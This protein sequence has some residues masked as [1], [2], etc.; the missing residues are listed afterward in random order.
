MS[1]SVSVLRVDDELESVGQEAAV[2]SIRSPVVRHWPEPPTSNCYRDRLQRLIVEK[3]AVESE[4]IQT[5]QLAKALEIKNQ[6]LQRDLHRMN[7]LLETVYSDLGKANSD[8]K[9]L[10]ETST[11]QRKEIAASSAEL[12][13]LQEQL[14]LAREHQHTQPPLQTPHECSN[15]QWAAQCNFVYVLGTQDNAF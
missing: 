13:T 14:N 6:Q 10:K 15:P 9:K 8:L 7:E 2:Q 11:S 12:K 1:R 5:A 3:A 4:L